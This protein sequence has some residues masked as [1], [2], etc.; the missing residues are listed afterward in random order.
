VFYLDAR[1]TDEMIERVD[2][3]VVAAAEAKDGG[4]VVVLLEPGVESRLS[5]EMAT[6]PSSRR[7]TRATL[8]LDGADGLGPVENGV[9]SLQMASVAN[10]FDFA[11]DN[12]VVVAPAASLTPI[13]LPGN[14]SNNYVN[15]YIGDGVTVP[16]STR[17][18]ETLRDVLSKPAPIQTPAARQGGF[19]RVSLLTMIASALG[20]VAVIA[21]GTASPAILAVAAL[22]GA[23]ALGLE[24]RR[25]VGQLI[26]S[27]LCPEIIQR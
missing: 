24:I 15:R 27:L 9:R 12:A 18:T 25:P 22:P 7:V 1:A 26:Y 5:G 3:A 10:R 4:R 17:F 21:T 8:A 13:V 6:R 19:A 2:R 11:L 23:V 16:V 20:V 14:S